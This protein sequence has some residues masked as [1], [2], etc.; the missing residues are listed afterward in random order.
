MN[1]HPESTY[2]FTNKISRATLLALE[3][4]MGKHG[5][6]TVLFQARLP[7]L[8]ERYPP[9]TLDKDLFYADISAINVA[10]ETTL[11]TRGGHGLA[12][13]T[14]RIVFDKALKN[15]GIMAGISNPAFK[16]LPLQAKLRLGLPAL[17]RILL[18]TCEL[19]LALQ[20]WEEGIPVLLIRSCPF[21]CERPIS[22]QAVCSMA[23]GLFAES[24]KWITDGGR[25][26]VTETECIAMGFEACRFTIR[27]I[28]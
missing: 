13:Q 7:E 14:G 4:L 28:G 19:D 24:I 2:R 16:A 18:Q 12:F 26:Q 15:L 3:D 20:E 8:A 21:C 17:Q 6:K 23:S 1:P 22:D 27:P 11:G 25:Y 10:L 9:D 5:L